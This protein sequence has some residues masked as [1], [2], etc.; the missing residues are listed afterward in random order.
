MDKDHEVEDE[1]GEGAD[2][3]QK[4]QNL[5]TRQELKLSPKT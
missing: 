4:L 5:P 1:H 2:L 3:T